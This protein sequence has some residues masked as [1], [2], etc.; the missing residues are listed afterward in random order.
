V[1]VAVERAGRK[2]EVVAKKKNLHLF[3]DDKSS[4]KEGERVIGQPRKGGA[5]KR[6]ATNNASVEGLHV[7]C[8][9]EREPLALGRP[10]RAVS[11]GGQ[12]QSKKI[13]IQSRAVRRL[14]TGSSTSPRAPRK[15]KKGLNAPSTSIKREKKQNYRRNTEESRVAPPIR[16]LKL[17]QET[18]TSGERK[19]THS[20]E[21]NKAKK[22]KREKKG[23]SAGV[24]W[25]C[26]GKF[27]PRR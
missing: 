12:G 22:K 24:K 8:E 4:K 6:T 26:R 21:C 13:G 15:G 1:G 9:R 3:Q 2:V 18:L 17:T 23:K 14:K 20:L 19:K 5:G 11:G 25:L 7:Q 16:T 10:G 27:E